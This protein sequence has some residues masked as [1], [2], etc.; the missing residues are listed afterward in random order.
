MKRTVSTVDYIRLADRMLPVADDK[1]EAAFLSFHAG[2]RRRI[3]SILRALKE[4]DPSLKGFTLRAGLMPPAG[5]VV[6]EEI[7]GFCRIPYRTVDG[8][9][10][11]CPGILMH[12]KGC[13]PHSPA[14][15][16]MVRLL[17]GAGSFLIIQFEGSEDSGRQGDIHPFLVRAAQALGGEGY[18]VIETYA[19]GPCRV[20]A[21]GCGTGPECRQPAKRLF[22][23]EACGFWINALC[24]G[25]AAFPVCGGGPRPVRWIRDWGLPAQDTRSVRYTTGILLSYTLLEKVF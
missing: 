16:E 5:A 14:V 10:P 17:S 1:P 9:I 11:S 12:W 21:R 24:R 23:L 4:D 22:A 3:R 20:C 19:C 6:E 18:S 13:P 25:A 8:S 2:H 15:T 7:R